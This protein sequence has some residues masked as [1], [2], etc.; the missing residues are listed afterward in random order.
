[1]NL[2]QHIL[3]ASGMALR[4]GLTTMYSVMR[5]RI[6]LTGNV[7]VLLRSML[8][9]DSLQI[10]VY[11]VLLVDSAPGR[12]TKSRR[13]AQITSNLRADAS[14]RHLYPFAS[15]PTLCSRFS[16]LARAPVSRRLL[17][18]REFASPWIE[19]GQDQ[20]ELKYSKNTYLS[21]CSGA[22]CMFKHPTYNR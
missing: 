13:L 19:I 21:F 3:R 9:I 11:S 12:I 14:V 10:V 22:T 20:L 16:L 4:I 15:N 2:C 7:C 17:D 1:M 8:S 18:P 5:A 6:P